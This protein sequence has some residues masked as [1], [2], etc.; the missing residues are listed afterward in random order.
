[1]I[2]PSPGGGTSSLLTFTI[3]GYGLYLPVIVQ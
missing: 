2:N 3:F 1:V